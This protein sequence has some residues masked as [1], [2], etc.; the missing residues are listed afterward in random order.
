MENL[1]MSSVEYCDLCR[2]YLQK[3]EVLNEKKRLEIENNPDKYNSSALSIY[4][5]VDSAESDILNGKLRQVFAEDY[6]E[7]DVLLEK[8]LM[9]VNN[10]Y[11]AEQIEENE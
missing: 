11:I 8:I 5:D 2:E 9:N 4:R 6:R 3:T 1:R 10:V 7:L